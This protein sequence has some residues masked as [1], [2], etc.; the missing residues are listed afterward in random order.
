MTEARRRT[1]SHAKNGGNG[2]VLATLAD[3]S[4]SPHLGVVEEA[5]RLRE[6][7]QQGHL[8]ERA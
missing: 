5:N 6:A 4:I 8:S 1:N 7:V 2:A 3:R